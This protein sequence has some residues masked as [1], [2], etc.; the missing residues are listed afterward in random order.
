MITKYAQRFEIAWDVVRP[1]VV[2]VLR[3]RGVSQPDAEDAVQEAAARALA[4]ETPFSDAEDLC[5]WVLTVARHAAIDEAR[6]RS[7]VDFG[8]DVDGE[9]S[10]DVPREALARVRTRAV[11]D[12]FQTL[13]PAEQAAIRFVGTEPDRRSAVRLNVRRFRARARLLALIDG[14]AALIAIR[15]ARLRPA[16]RSVA[17][18][19]I[20]IAA[21]VAVSIPNSD[22]ARQPLDRRDQHQPLESAATAPLPIDR[23]LLL[24]DAGQAAPAAAAALQMNPSGGRPPVDG[25]R[26]R[27]EVPLPSGSWGGEVRPKEPQDGDDFV[28]VG[29]LTVP[30]ECVPAPDVAWPWERTP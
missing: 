7:R 24:A 21:V 30:Y 8:V 15:W 3:R 19:A 4:A 22:Q 27:V 13:S 2:L 23:A 26:A 10:A 29:V 1:R 6:K 28:C 14:I 25:P 17:Q 5:R 16:A 20:P 9:S 11:A 18:V 12:A